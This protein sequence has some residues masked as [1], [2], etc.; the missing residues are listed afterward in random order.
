MSG[1]KDWAMRRIAILD[2]ETTGTGDADECVEVAACVYDL[3]LRAPVATYATLLRAAKTNDAAVTNGIPDALLV[4]AL[5]PASAWV[6]FDL[7]FRE[8]RA[9]AVVAYNAE[10]DRRF[11]S[12]NIAESWPWICA[13]NDIDWKTGKRGAS[14]VVT[15]VA[16]GV[17]VV[18]AHRAL[19][20]VDTL[21]RCFQRVAEVGMNVQEMIESAMLPR[22]LYSA[23]V[24][25]DDRHLA[26]E[27]GFK[28]E[29]PPGVTA[30]KRW[31]RRLTESEAAAL[32]FQTT[33]L[34][35]KP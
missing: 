33:R 32:S 22:H 7:M 23:E 5:D 8:C 35:A 34:E 19:A 18:T 11:V 1:N 10:F 30:K 25:Y 3:E 15:A 29:Y 13:M 20:D 2:T 28:W 26:S 6:R 14:L 21:V 17:P 27:A 16:L 9:E 24:S 12:P 4:D 31:L